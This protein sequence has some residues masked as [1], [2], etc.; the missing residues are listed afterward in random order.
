MGPSALVFVLGLPALAAST[1]LGL[2][3]YCARRGGEEHNDTGGSPKLP[4]FTFVIPAHNEA[5]G[6]ARTIDTLHA[7]DYPADKFSVVV[8]ADNCSDETGDQAKRAGARVIERNDESKR[9]KGYALEYAFD[10]LVAEAA[11]D[12]LVVVDADTDASPN[13]LREMA[14][15]L[16]R[17]ELVM[18]AH[19]GVRNVD[20]SW[21]TRLMDVAFTLYHG[22]RSSARERLGLSA[23]LRGNGMAFSLEALRRV[24]HRSYSLVEDVEYGIQLGLQGIRVAYVENAVVRGEMVAGNQGSKSQRLRWEQGRRKLISQYVPMLLKRA[25]HERSGLLLDLALDV[26]I[27]PLSTIVAYTAV[28][29]AAATLVVLT[30]LGQPIVVLPW[31]LS[32]AGLALYLGRGLQMSSQGPRALLTLLHGPQYAAWKIALRLAS[33]KTRGNEWVRTARSGETVGNP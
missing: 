8:I 15:Y 11:S 3:G 6:I 31:T 29:S 25:Y 28:G 18:Q 33:S 19:Y 16:T 21:R 22:V 4:H 23:G 17:G 26:L 27:P 30:G 32:L 14:K 12:A 13:L 7:V 1:Y 2:L 10:L 9:G 5:R 20:D 24:P